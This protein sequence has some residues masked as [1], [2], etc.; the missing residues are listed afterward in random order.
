MK[1]KL[2][3]GEDKSQGFSLSFDS[4]QFH[5]SLWRGGC[6]AALAWAEAVKDIVRPIQRK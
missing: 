3:N 4:D 1:L 5:Y 2:L 6:W